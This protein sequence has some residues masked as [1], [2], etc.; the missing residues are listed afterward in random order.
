MRVRLSAGRRS[1]PVA[2]RRTKKLRRA[3]VIVSSM[4]RANWDDCACD[5][6]PLPPPPTVP[7]EWREPR[8][9]DCGHRRPIGVELAGTWHLC[10]GCAYQAR[11]FRRHWLL[12]AVAFVCALVVTC[13]ARAAGPCVPYC[14]RPGEACR[15]PARLGVLGGV[16]V[17]YCPAPVVCR[18]VSK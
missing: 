7:R 13:S 8:I 17:C 16:L 11:R 15:P 3:A 9:F 1:R 4:P 12:L 2:D 14:P 10:P 5:D 18:G 6:E